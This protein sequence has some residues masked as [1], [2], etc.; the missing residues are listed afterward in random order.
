MH[1]NGCKKDSVSVVRLSSSTFWLGGSG[2]VGWTGLGN[3]VVACA[4]LGRKIRLKPVP[5]KSPVKF[6]KHPAALGWG[7]K[8]GIWIILAVHFGDLKVGWNSNRCEAGGD[9]DNRLGGRV[10]TVQELLF[11]QRLASLIW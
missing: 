3:G 10:F 5:A 7:C 8:A 9:R 6:S 11:K 1:P 2:G 4:L